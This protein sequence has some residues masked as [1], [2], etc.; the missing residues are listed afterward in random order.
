MKRFNVLMMMLFV[1]SGLLVITAAVNA[2][3][4]GT[5]KGEAV[6]IDA[7]ANTLTVKA[8][9]KDAAEGTTREIIF[10]I[11]EETAILKSGGRIALA[12]VQPG[13]RVIV[14]WK[15]DGEARLALSIGVDHVEPAA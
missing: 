8:S 1:L 3:T 12:D 5:A 7:E 10:V 14:N 4:A 11:N 9:V 13:D 2:E 6:I 15:L